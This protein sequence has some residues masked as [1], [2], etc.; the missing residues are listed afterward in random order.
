M[1]YGQDDDN[2][3]YA[4]DH[5]GNGGDGQKSTLNGY[6]AYQLGA[7]Y[8]KNSVSRMVAQKTVVIQSKD[9]IYLLQLRAEGPQAD[10]DALKGATV[11]I[12]Q[13]TTITP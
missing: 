9:G 2:E 13:K 10:V 5:N 3:G 7:S 1:R 11:V 4:N 8:T 12:S 6:P